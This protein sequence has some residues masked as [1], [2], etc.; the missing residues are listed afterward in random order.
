MKAKKTLALLLVLAMSF[1]LLAGC[2][3]ATQNSDPPETNTVSTAPENSQQGSTI[4]IAEE[5]QE[6]V[7]H[8]VVNVAIAADLGTWD[9]FNLTSQ[10]ARQGVYQGLGYMID[11]EFVPSLMKSYTLSDDL[12]VLHC[13]IFDNIYDS[14]GVHMTAADV[15]WS[16]GMAQAG[17]QLQVSDILDEFV[18]TGE[19]TFDIVLLDALQVGRI[20]KFLKFYIV[21]RESYEASPDGMATDPVGTGPLMMTD[22]VDGYSFTLERRDNYWQTDESQISYLDTANAQTINYYIISESTQRAIALQN[23]SIDMVISLSAEDLEQIRSNEDLWL[24]DVTAD[25]SM[26]FVPNCDESSLMSDINLRLACYYAINPQAIITAVYGGAAYQNYSV[27]PVWSAGYQ[28]QWAEQENYYTVYDVELAKEY[29]EKSSYA[30]ESLK[31]ICQAGSNSS[32]S[33]QIVEGFLN[34]LGIKTELVALER[35]VFSAYMENADQWDIAIYECACN[36]YWIDAANGDLTQAKTTWG[37]STNFVYDDELQEML[38]YCIS[39][40]TAS[41]ENNDMLHNY[42]IDHA[43]WYSMVNYV[44]YLVVP[45][46]CTS[47]ALNTTKRLYAAG[48]IFS[49]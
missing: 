21:C 8:D 34:E 13:E 45:K 17:T 2:G 46:W 22:L 12:T 15:V 25:K 9:P 35:N 42:I 16:A 41:D 10:E 11:G 28:E 31:I 14:K 39:M 18:Q 47:V 3:E 23:G 40:K 29:L 44:S 4:D 26:D 48:C 19:Y 6:S 7:I 36:T 38:E 27:A 33:A 32:A 49:E 20:D 1:S 30:G 5:K 24:S 43:Y 37:S